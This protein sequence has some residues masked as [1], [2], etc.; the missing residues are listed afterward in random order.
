MMLG[1]KNI[2]VKIVFFSWS[3]PRDT[4]WSQVGGRLHILELFRNWHDA[5]LPCN[6]VYIII[7][8]RVLSTIRSSFYSTFRTCVLDLLCSQ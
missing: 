1:H 6:A 7:L 3:F 4:R 2:K 5:P 8:I